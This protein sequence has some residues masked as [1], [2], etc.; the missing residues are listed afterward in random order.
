MKAV[1]LPVAMDT[2]LQI[3]FGKNSRLSL[4]LE[5][6]KNSPSYGGHMGYYPTP[7]GNPAM[8]DDLLEHGAD[9]HEVHQA[10]TGYDFPVTM[11]STIGNHRF[12]T[13]LCQLGMDTSICFRLNLQAS[14]FYL[15]P[16]R[17]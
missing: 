1:N 14:I 8:F 5:S 9:I 6:S 17:H 11:A 7:I 13:K 2:G 12:V 10:F 3:W 16:L 15:T 4:N